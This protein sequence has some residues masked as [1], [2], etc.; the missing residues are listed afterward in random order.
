MTFCHQQAFRVPFHVYWGATLLRTVRGCGQVGMIEP[1][2]D[3]PLR[4]FKVLGLGPGSS[5][6]GDVG[7]T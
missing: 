3:R 5:S 1:W 6:P 4:V 7:F 2:P